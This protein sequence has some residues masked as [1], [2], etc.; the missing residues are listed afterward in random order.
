MKKIVIIL[1]SF[2]NII[3]AQIDTTVWYPMA[4]GNYWE[5]QDAG[6]LVR[7]G[8]SV[9]GD[10][11]MPNGKTYSIFKIEDLNNHHKIYS[12]RRVDNNSHLYI[13]KSN[14]EYKY[15]DFTKK[16]YESWRIDSIYNRRLVK[17]DTTFS[18]LF[19]MK[20]PRIEFEDLYFTINNDTTYIERVWQQVNKGIGDV[21]LGE[22]GGSVELVGATINNHSYGKVSAIQ[23]GG[24]LQPL[25]GLSQNHPNPFN[26]STTIEFL[27]YEGT[28][29]RLI[30]YDA[31]GREVAVLKN[32]VMSPGFYRATF[33]GSKLA[34]GVYFYMLS[35]P[36]YSLVKKLML[37]K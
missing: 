8:I 19:G 35:T 29:T 25:I 24:D 33:D 37:M 22:W 17:K 15:Y 4:K 9:I 27:I 13:W 26:P 1:L 18:Q 2:T 10:T 36:K 12:Y 3:L 5:Y 28:P 30:V 20:V 31:I 21:K 32:E 16:V 6:L 34:S 7:K 11:L 14:D 23:K